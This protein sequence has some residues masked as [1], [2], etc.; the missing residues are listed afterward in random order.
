MDLSFLPLVNAILN[1]IALVLLFV[2][3]WFIK[4]KQWEKH[5]NT[6]IAAFAMSALFLVFYLAHKV[7]RASSGGDLHSSYNG[8]GLLKLGYQVMLLTHVLLAMVVPVF[9]IRLIWL[10]TKR[11]D[12]K[13]RRLGKIA[14]PIWVYVSITGVLIYLMLYPFNPP[15]S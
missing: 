7:W 11:A 14:F 12:D 8:T 1:G 10:G 9:A 13:H 3:L 2:G 6:M 15:A 4:Q 5:R